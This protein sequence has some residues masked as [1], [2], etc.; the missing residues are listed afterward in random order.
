M[1]I[2]CITQK[3][4]HWKVKVKVAQSCQT[5]CDPM[6]CSPWNSLG[7]NTG[8]GSPSLL[9]GIFPTQESNWGL[10]HCRQILN[11]LSYRGS[12]FHLNSSI[13][14]IFSSEFLQNISFKA[15]FPATNLIDLVRPLQ[16]KKMYAWF[17]NL[18]QTHTASSIQ[19]KPFRALTMKRSFAVDAAAIWANARK[20]LTLINVC[21]EMKQAEE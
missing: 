16:N 15:H 6:D 3:P 14:K 4:F 11:Q 21:R 8:V 5:L 17:M 7:Q 1:P 19:C 13:W 18:T 9:Q 2:F 12:P 10:L 20:H